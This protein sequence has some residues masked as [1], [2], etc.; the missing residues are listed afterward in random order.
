MKFF[1]QDYRNDEPPSL[2]P[3]VFRHRYPLGCS[4]HMFVCVHIKNFHIL[5][6]YIYTSYIEEMCL[7]LYGSA[8]SCTPLSNKNKTPHP[9][10]G[11]VGGSSMHSTPSTGTSN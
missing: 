6:I 2:L 8:F 9:C 10:A 7:S 4:L 11:G 5:Y 3:E 1:A